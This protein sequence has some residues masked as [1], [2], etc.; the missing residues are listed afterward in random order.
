MPEAPSGD[1]GPHVCTSSKAALAHMRSFRSTLAYSG[2]CY[3]QQD[4]HCSRRTAFLYHERVKKKGTAKVIYACVWRDPPAPPPQLRLHTPTHAD[5]AV[6]EPVRGGAAALITRPQELKL[7]GNLVV[8]VITCTPRRCE[9]EN[10]TYSAFIWSE[11]RVVKS[12]PPPKKTAK[13]GRKM[14]NGLW[15]SANQRSRHPRAWAEAAF[16]APR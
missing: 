14:P 5:L 2:F 4:G 6:K 11:S 8:K 10:V 1:E 3:K 12:P 7:S 16:L 9:P 13:N 15:I